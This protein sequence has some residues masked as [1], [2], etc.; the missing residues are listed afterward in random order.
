MSQP[1]MKQ[2]DRKGNVDEEIDYPLDGATHP[3]VI[4]HYQVMRELKQNETNFGVR[5]LVR[6]LDDPGRGYF[7]QNY[8][9][10]LRGIFPNV[11]K[12]KSKLAK[13]K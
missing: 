9:S 12:N 8:L 11:K 4:L 10:E 5:D 3:A 6:M 2:K 7:T 1:L 13:G